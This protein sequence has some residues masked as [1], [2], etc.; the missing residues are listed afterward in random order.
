MKPWSVILT[1]FFMAPLA[2]AQPTLEPGWPVQTGFS[3][4]QSPVAGQLDDDDVL[5]FA[6]ASQDGYLYVFNHDGTLVNGWPQYM[7]TALWP[8]PYANICSSPAVYDINDDGLNEI[9]VG[10]FDSYMYV[11]SREGNLL[12]GW[13][14]QS[15]FTIFST[16]ALGDID[17]DGE[18]EIIYGDNSGG[19]YALNVDGSVC[20][21]FPYPTPYVVRSSP[22]LGDLDHD[23]IDEIVITA[24]NSDYHLYAIDGDG[25][26]LPGFPIQF[27]NAIGSNSSPTLADVDVDGD[28]EIVVGDRSG[29]LH[30]LHHDGQYLP[31]WPIDAGYS[32]QSCPTVVNLDDD[33]ELEIIVGMNDSQVIIYEVDGSYFPGWPQPT[34]YTVISSASVGDLDG[35]NE[36]EVVVGCN[37]G[38]V[39]GWNLDGTAVP[40]FP[41]TD[42]TYTVYSSPL[43]EDLDYDGHL[44]MVLGCNDTWI[45]CWDLGANTYNP[46]LL[47]WPQFR[48]DA[49]NTAAL[50]IE[51][52]IEFVM[53]GLNPPIVIPPMGGNFEFFVSLMSSETY[54]LNFDAWVMVTL[55]DS[56]LYGPVLGPVDVVMPEGQ[57]LERY[58]IQEVPGSAPAGEYTYTG[59]VGYYPDYIW[60]EESFNFTKSITGAG[61]GWVSQWLN[62]G[63]PFE[64][65]ADPAPPADFT[66]L[67]NYPNPFNLSTTIS[68]ALSGAGKINLSVY[69]ISGRLVA[70]L[71]NG[72]RGAG[73]HEVTF[74]ASNLASGL[75]IYRIKAGDFTAVRKMVLMK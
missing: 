55:P 50:I 71:T 32:L 62:T 56:T 41:L 14:F 40:G 44:E 61:D 26:D 1:L 35:D 45:Y 42:P 33:P 13:P 18:M 68:F 25:S 43:L 69:D 23:G 63:D 64:I 15:G 19:I 7:G 4:S 57:T 9:I 58:R 6:I 20:T 53:Y 21:G 2:M 73:M 30:V 34:A 10:C 59:Y 66:L 17:D 12:P 38:E 5:E 75:Y 29:Y 70:T 24:D 3:V 16:P 8:D 72:W 31:N 51:P 60:E 54:T 46:D 49:R 28:L 27:A 52:E 37:T 22:A 65:Q 11:F 67:E 48:L 39:Y 36:L 47:P 74:D